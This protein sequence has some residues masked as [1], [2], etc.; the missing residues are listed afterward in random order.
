MSD[1]PDCDVTDCTDPA[2]RP[3]I[4]QGERIH[5]C[6]RYARL[7]ESAGTN[8][9]EILAAAAYTDRGDG[10]VPVLDERNDPRLGAHDRALD[11]FEGFGH[12][13]EHVREDLREMGLDAD[14]LTP[15]QAGVRGGLWRSDVPA[16]VATILDRVPGQVEISIQ[17]AAD[18]HHWQV[19]WD[20]VEAE[21]PLIGDGGT[22]E[23]QG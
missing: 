5:T 13:P 8:H 22:D 21:P 10:V 14:D 4:R 23:V 7:F 18:G 6:R 9:G 20:C 17:P 15:C 3:A 11:V 12:V 19:E 16:L 1:N 2:T